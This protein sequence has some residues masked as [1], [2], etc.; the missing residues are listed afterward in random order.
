MDAPWRGNVRELSNVIERA[1]L[2][3]QGSIITPNDLPH[4][5]FS[6]NQSRRK[7]CILDEGITF[8]EA[9]SNLERN[10][11]QEAYKEYKSSRKVAT[12]LGIS[13]TKANNLIRKYIT[14]IEE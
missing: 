13:Q 7:T 5:M 1:V 6:M 12:K 11:I 9:I 3:M 2:T 10:I 8:D 14:K 4:S